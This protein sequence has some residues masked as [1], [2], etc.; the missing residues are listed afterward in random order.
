M[1]KAKPSYEELR[2]EL[3][4]VVAE[5]QRD[6]LDVDLALQHYRRG[7]ELIRQI[8]AYLKNAENTVTELK[9]RFDT[10]KP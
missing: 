6:D 8:E 9:S 4:A 1:A 7:L 2:T 3:D 10:D 5:L